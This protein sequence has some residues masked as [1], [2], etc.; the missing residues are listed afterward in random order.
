MIKVT[1]TLRGIG[2]SFENVIIDFLKLF[3]SPFKISNKFFVFGVNIGWHFWL[4]T[5]T[6][7]MYGV[8]WDDPD[9]FVI[10]GLRFT[11]VPIL[12]IIDH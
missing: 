3:L 10:K 2:I 8:S 4:L 11:N 6:W 7:I 5:G 9:K 12:F 1:K